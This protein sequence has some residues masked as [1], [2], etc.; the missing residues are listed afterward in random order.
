MKNAL[1]KET[2]IRILKKEL[3]RLREQYG[4]ERVAI[5][6]SFAKDSQTTQSDVD[7]LVQLMKPLGLEFVGL[8]YDLERL[9]GRKVDLVTFD[10]LN[11]SMENPRYK[12]IASDIQRTL[13]YV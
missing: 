2:V 6:G 3:P 13:A 12:Q 9:L 4:V 11:S 5:Y 10:T 8:A 1:G 7:V